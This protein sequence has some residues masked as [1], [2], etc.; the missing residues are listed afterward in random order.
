MPLSFSAPLSWS[1]CDYRR[2][3]I[4]LVPRWVTV[5]LMVASAAAA[6][7]ARSATATE[8][9]MRHLAALR[10]HN[11]A[12][13]YSLASKE[14]RRHF[15]RSEFE[16]MVKRAHPEIASSAYAFV[17]R[18]HEADGYLYVTVKVHGRNGK[19]VEALYELVL[20]GNDLKVNALSSRRDDG[21]L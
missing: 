7:E 14:A 2:V 11:F 9:V 21:V 18:T 8:L 4:R 10:A 15:T 17:V 20:E 1:A 13:A 16:W 12:A 19:D 3:P 5:L 6:D